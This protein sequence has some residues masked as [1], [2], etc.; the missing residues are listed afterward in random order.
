MID[1]EEGIAVG[2]RMR[3]ELRGRVQITHDVQRSLWTATLINDA[4]RVVEA[5]ADRS[6]TAALR[7]L[8]NE[9][10]V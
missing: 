4:G 8:A 10:G 2:Y 6:V 3:L 1:F 7:Q 5:R 9:V